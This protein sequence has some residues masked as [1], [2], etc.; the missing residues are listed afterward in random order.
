MKK[1][2]EKIKV[3]LDAKQKEVLEAKIEVSTLEKLR[4]NS[5]AIQ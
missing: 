4:E 3:L 5:C 1:N 2:G